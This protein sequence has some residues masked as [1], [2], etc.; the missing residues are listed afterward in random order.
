MALEKRLAIKDRFADRSAYGAHLARLFGFYVVAEPQWQ[1]LAA[2]AINDYPA[3]CK[4]LWLADDLARLG[5]TAEAIAHLPRCAGVPVFD[6]SAATLGAVYVLEGAT[7]GGQIL[8]PLAQR[9]LALTAHS[10][11]AYFASYGAQVRPMWQQFG[12]MLE[13]YCDTPD[14]V[15]RAATAAQA[16]F[17]A[18]EQ[19]LC[20][21]DL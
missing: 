13:A 5:Y 15:E 21:R 10:G 7:L 20:E 8:L 3:R 12:R 6:D 4:T 2:V 18:L 17:I 16:T 1:A 11:A 19:W 14:K 9:R